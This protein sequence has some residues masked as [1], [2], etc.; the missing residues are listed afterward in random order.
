MSKE[1]IEQMISEKM[2]NVNEAT[3][4]ELKLVDDVYGLLDKAVGILNNK[5]PGI[6]GQYKKDVKDILD[7]A[8]KIKNSTLVLKNKLNKND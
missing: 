3:N 2:Q 8:T 7:T 4:T 5:I 1:L 6:S